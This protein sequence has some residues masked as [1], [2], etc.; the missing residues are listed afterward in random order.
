MRAAMWCAVTPV[1]FAA[2][3]AAADFGIK[4]GLEPSNIDEI[5]T[6]A[7]GS[8]PDQNQRATSFHAVLGSNVDIRAPIAVESLPRSFS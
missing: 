7:A 8:V 4:G 3:V 2:H 5:A 6:I 1:I